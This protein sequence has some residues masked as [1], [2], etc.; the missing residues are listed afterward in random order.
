MF[1]NKIVFFYKYS[2]SDNSICFSIDIGII[3]F[4][5]KD[6]LFTFEKNAFKYHN[7]IY[8]KEDIFIYVKFYF[9]CG[10]CFFF[11][12]GLYF[13]YTLIKFICGIKFLSIFLFLE[14]KF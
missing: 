9:S 13:F 4:L 3:F 1:C 5:G 11:F 7:I 12:L 2:F 6:I 8:I 14:K 10:Y